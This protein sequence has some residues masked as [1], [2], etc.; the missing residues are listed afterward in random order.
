MLPAATI[1]LNSLATCKSWVLARLVQLAKPW[2]SDRWPC[3]TYPFPCIFLSDFQISNHSLLVKLLGKMKIQQGKAVYFL[4]NRCS[5]P[6]IYC[7]LP[8]SNKRGLNP[9][10][11]RGFQVNLIS[12]WFRAE[13]V[14]H[15]PCA[16]QRQ[17]QGG[18]GA[19]LL[20]LR[21]ETQPVRACAGAWGAARPR[22][23]PGH[24]GHG[25]WACSKW[26]HIP[27]NNH[28]CW[29]TCAGRFSHSSE[30]VCRKQELGN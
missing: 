4:K 10:G 29:E 2:I 9:S 28:L 25:H 3:I 18:D 6:Q 24:P 15:V 12:L 1:K 21:A 26:P 13:R 11:L 23:Q 30:T 19:A 16:V 20:Q 17:L 27:Q 22:P 14:P 5:D 8:S 7:L